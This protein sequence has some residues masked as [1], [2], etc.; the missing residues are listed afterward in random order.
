MSQ[1][2]KQIRDF[3]QV[4]SL[5]K[6]IEHVRYPEDAKEASRQFLQDQ[7]EIVRKRV[8]K[9]LKEAGYPKRKA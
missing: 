5:L 8:L 1:P 9:S 6:E 3:L 4:T 7:V 2:I